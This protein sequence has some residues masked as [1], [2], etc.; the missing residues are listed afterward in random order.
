MLHERYGRKGV[1]RKHDCSPL[2]FAQSAVF[3]PVALCS[4]ASAAYS[5]GRLSS[6]VELKVG[7]KEVSSGRCGAFRPVN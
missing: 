1:S 3:I 5:A 6:G 7:G 2:G 4:I